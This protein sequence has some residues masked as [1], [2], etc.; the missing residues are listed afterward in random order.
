MNDLTT[1]ET[2]NAIAIPAPLVPDRAALAAFSAAVFKNADPMG[3]VSTRI[4]LDDGNEGPAIQI[5]AITLGDPAY[6]DV[7]FERARQAAA[8][9]APAV[10]APPVTTL[11]TGKSAKTDDIYE[12]VTLSVDCDASPVAALGILESII[13]KPT[14]G[15]ASGGEWVDPDTGEVERKV[16]LHWRLNVP[17][18][19]SDEHKLLRDARALATKL[20]G[21]D[22]TGVAL[23]HP[24]RW[25]GSLHRKRQP[26]FAEIIMNND[27]E[28]DLHEAVAAL[29][30][31]S[32]RDEANSG[33]V[34]TASRGQLAKNPEHVALALQV[35]PNNE[36]WNGWNNIGLATWG[37][38]GGSEI[39]FEAFAVWSAKSSKNDPA[40]TRERWEHYGRSPP[41]V[42]G[43]GTLVHHARKAKPGW[44]PQTAQEVVSA[45]Q[46]IDNG[47][48]TQDG[49]ARIFA[50][51]YAGKLRYCHH[52][53]TW[54]EWVGSHWRRDEKAL[55]FQ[56]V[57]EL[58][59]EFSDAKSIIKS[60]VKEVRRV[61]FAG[62][63]ERF[64]QGDPAF[65][66]TSDDWD[67]DLYLLG[68]SGGTV[69]LMTGKL[70]APDPADGITKVTL[71]APADR[72]DCPLWLK[73][74]NE[75]F[76]EDVEMIRF[77][78]QWAGYCLT[79][80]TREHALL[81]GI[82]D[83]GNG[84]GVFLNTISGI[85]KDYAV[86]ATMQTF[87]ASSQERHSTEL[88][89]LR[90]ARLVTASETERGRGWA[91][92]RIKALTGGDPIT[93]RF[94]RQ[95]D[96]T[97]TPQFKLTIVGNH[98]P[99]LR[100]VD[101]ATRRRYNIIPFNRKPL[102]VDRQ[103]NLKLMGEAPAILRWMIDGCLDWQ[104]NGLVRPQSVIDATNEYFADQDNLSRWI[105]ESCDCDP[106]NKY[107][108]A[109]AT[110]LYLSW[111]N[112]MQSAGEEPGTQKSFA[113]RL[114]TAGKGI[115]AKRTKQGML[116]LGIR[117][118]PDVSYQETEDDVASGIETNFP[119]HPAPSGR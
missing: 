50:T 77:L 87:I 114:L 9:H 57:R 97:Y 119:I 66:V 4:F 93:C 111:K 6:L 86:A 11:R 25:P 55:A 28:I 108:S 23:V 103:L 3:F 91:E 113:D 21:G 13:G 67:R 39:G 81:F 112:F 84:K 100:T 19:T 105:A 85:M 42:I 80:D 44:M 17:T 110:E 29:R 63:V 98:K 52:A 31:A 94:M 88:A 75:T 37:A 47:T 59:R 43:Y 107:K 1:I 27:L 45:T 62:G 5:E 2:T 40:K 78:Q 32:G 115:L 90:G 8:W 61:T 24:F 65:A 30:E 60:E 15:V 64:A 36:D 117:L 118:V 51:R 58:G 22:P 33:D 83:G 68:T 95:D 96:F 14:I 89:M 53:G 102:V 7:V 71:V 73:F 12:G 16:H 104:Q 70:R 82:G 38:T 109:T 48:I 116:Y 46:V 69:D 35:V 106:G 76:G 54:Y 72:A 92:A 41:T 79:G 99:E 20:V 101:A 74:L 10:F 26:K 34:T 56:F 18:K 49:I